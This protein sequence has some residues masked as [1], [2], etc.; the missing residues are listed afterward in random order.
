MV[1]GLWLSCKGDTYN[2][3]YYITNNND[4]TDAS[5][6]PPD[7]DT[8]EIDAENQLDAR[9]D[10][11]GAENYS[12]SGKDSADGSSPPKKYCVNLEWF[13][14]YG[15]ELDKYFH[16]EIYPLIIKNYGELVAFRNRHFPMALHPYAAFASEA[17]ECA[18]F[19]NAFFAYHSRLFSEQEQWNSRD[20]LE[21]TLDQ[22]EGYALEEGL[23]TTTFNSCLESG[24]TE[25]ILNADVAEGLTRGVEG[26]PTFFVNDRVI[27]G[28]PPYTTFSGVIEDELSLCGK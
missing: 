4:Q 25:Y 24:E 9:Y 6:N 12:D 23:D 16:N 20:S 1:A 18:R 27:Y 17:A 10:V 8:R 2:T 3:T 28:V 5:V 7:L 14:D 11:L 13:L 15:N 21:A 19:Q 22:F 26:T